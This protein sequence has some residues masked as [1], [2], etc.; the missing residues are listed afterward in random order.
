[1]AENSKHGPCPSERIDPGRLRD[2]GF[3]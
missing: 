3:P 1:M 2:G